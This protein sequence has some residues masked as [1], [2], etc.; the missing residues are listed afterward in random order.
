MSDKFW[1]YAP[2]TLV[3][4]NAIVDLWP[5]TQ[6]S[7]ER[8]LNAITRLLI[9]LTLFGFLFTGAITVLMVGVLTCLSLVLVYKY[10]YFS[11]KDGK[12]PGPDPDPDTKKKVETFQNRFPKSNS[13]SNSKSDGSSEIVL[14]TRESL[15]KHLQSSYHDGKKK[16]PFNNVLL[17]EIHDA[18]D[19]KSAPPSFHP[20]VEENIQKNVKR[21]VQFM[22][23]GIDNTNKQLFSSLWDNFL[24]D[25][26]NRVF[27]S[28][29][30]T[31]IEPGDQA[32]L[33][34]YLYGNM[35]SSKESNLE[36]AIARVQDSYRYTLY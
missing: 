24:L 9:V 26:S 34:Q 12:K 31:R 6:M 25:Q 2:Y 11:P 5:T 1:F 21:S 20:T 36:A 8:K 15:E 16:N 19:R 13:N 30:N 4:K 32:A 14:E 7:Y 33:G 27:Y 29:A 35:P 17:T 18:P 23:S 10:R 22:N 28:T 3:D